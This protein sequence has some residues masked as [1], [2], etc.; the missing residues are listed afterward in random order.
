MKDTSIPFC[1]EVG[2]DFKMGGGNEKLKSRNKIKHLFSKISRARHCYYC[3]GYLKH[4][5]S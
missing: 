1:K 3:Y 2:S 4:A 5:F